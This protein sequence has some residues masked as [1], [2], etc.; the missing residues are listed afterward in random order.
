V[1]RIILGLSCSTT[2]S[3][4]LF[5]S[6][7]EGGSFHTFYHR[8]DVPVSGLPVGRPLPFRTGGPE[9]RSNRDCLVCPS[10]RG[11]PDPVHLPSPFVT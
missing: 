3:W 1:W 10:L 6:I 7:R 8:T 11:S 5:A 4:A 9:V 2:L